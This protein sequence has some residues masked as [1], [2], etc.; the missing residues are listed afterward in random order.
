MQIISIILIISSVLSFLI[1]A[2]FFFI[3]TTFKYNKKMT[4]RV[5][6]SLIKVKHKRNVP[7][8][9]SNLP[10]GPIHIKIIKNRSKGLYEY[11]VNQKRY[12]IRYIEY[13]TSRQM[14][15]MLSVIYLRKFPKIAYIK[16]DVCTKLYTFHIFSIIFAF[17]GI[18][19]LINALF[20]LF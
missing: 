5:T 2:S 20:V 8:F 9:C 15:R 13:V 11:S 6:A 19:L 12:K 14:P 4:D 17:F 3:Y 18:F 1:A 10:Y 16:T 7:E